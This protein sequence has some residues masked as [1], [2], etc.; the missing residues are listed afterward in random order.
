MG[1]YFLDADRLRV[2]GDD[3][4]FELDRVGQEARQE[5]SAFSG[6]VV[7]DFSETRKSLGLFTQL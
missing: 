4:Y 2:M 7:F 6:Q 5:R 3:D 1:E